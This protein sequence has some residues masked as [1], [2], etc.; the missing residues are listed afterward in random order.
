[1]P[2]G[3]PPKKNVENSQEKQIMTV[4][5][6]KDNKTKKDKY[7]CF[8]CG[9]EYVETN[10]YKS[11]GK[12]FN[13][14]GR[15]PYCRQCI[16]KFYQYY[17][18]KY[19]NEGCLTPEENAVKRVC[20]AM[21]VYYSKVNFDSSM[22]TI[23]N[24]DINISPMAQYMKTIGFIQYKNKSYDDTVFEEEQKKLTESLMDM[25]NVSDRKVDEKT[26]QFFGVG[27]TDEDYIFL[28]REYDDWTARHECNTK[29]QEEVFKRICFKQLEILKATQRGEDTKNLDDTFQKLLDTAKLQPKQNSG[30]T[31]ADN[32]TFGTLIDKWENTR[33]LP[34]IDEELRDVDKIA[35][36][37]NIFYK[38]HLSKMMGLKNCMS[39]LYSKFMKKYTVEKPE[40]NNDENNEALFDAVFGN[41]PS[42][43]NDQGKVVV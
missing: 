35:L 9:K 40:Y 8:Y 31:T 38:G 3:R 15:T 11:F 37:I 6:K 23:K 12:V 27:F 26:I 4:S 16:E 1:M 21:D 34:E 13:N 22:N 30:D 24:R 10:F 39:N 33:P 18:D 5:K 19:T 25:S 20:M 29:A 32:Q 14:V 42:E 41:P 17:F 36:Y 7:I 28:K 2:R 43:T